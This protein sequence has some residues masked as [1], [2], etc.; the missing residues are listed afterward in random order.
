L[1]RPDYQGCSVM[2]Y[3]EVDVPYTRIHEF[4]HFHPEKAPIDKT[5]IY[6]EYSKII[7]E[8]SEPYYPVNTPKTLSFSNDT[9]PMPISWT[10]C[11]LVGDWE[12]TVISTWTIP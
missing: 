8:S 3:A 4:K 7:G 5:V 11:G 10:A 6:K 12:G 2:N 1:D 9:K